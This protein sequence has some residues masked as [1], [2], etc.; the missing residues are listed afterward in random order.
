MDITWHG[1][2]CFTFRDKGVT[3]VVNPDKDSGQHKADVVLTSLKGDIPAIDG[4]PRIFNTPGE[5]EVKGVPIL[6]FRAWTKSK[7]KE[8]EEGGS[9][10]TI[11]FFFEMNDIKVCHLG[12]LGHVLTSEMVKEI[13]DV[14]I[15]LVQGGKSSNLVGKKA[16]EVIESIDPKAVIP[17]GTGNLEEFL[18]DLGAEKVEGM[19]TFSI[20]A[21]SE[22]PSDKRMYILLKKS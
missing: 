8:E 2:T 22:L 13:G 9:E 10:P 14:D 3:L 11:I 20:K 17:M 21:V 12:D 19:D 6:G 15:L 16:V 18:Q 5:Y 4:D 1:N 7:T